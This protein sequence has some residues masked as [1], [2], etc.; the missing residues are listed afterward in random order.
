MNSPVMLTPFISPL[1]FIFILPMG[2]LVL[3]LFVKTDSVVGSLHGYVFDADSLIGP[4]I[5]EIPQV[6]VD[7]FIAILPIIVI[8]II[9][10][11]LSFHLRPRPICAR[12]SRARAGAVARCEI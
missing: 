5:N 8:L 3:N 10:Q 6:M 1:T 12:A 11:K 9:F 4:F 2:V 7:S